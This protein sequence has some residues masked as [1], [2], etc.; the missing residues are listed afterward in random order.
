V[1]YR[2]GRTRANSAIL[3]L[4][5]AG[6]VRIDCNQA[7]GSTDVVLDVSGWFE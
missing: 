6:D 2:A 7:A 1:N 5:A 3:G 4:G